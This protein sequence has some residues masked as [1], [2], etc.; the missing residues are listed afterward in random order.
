MA[1]A[2]DDADL[3]LFGLDRAAAEES[4]SLGKGYG[5]QPT[6]DVAALDETETAFFTLLTKLRTLL[7]ERMPRVAEDEKTYYRAMLYSVEQM[8]GSRNLK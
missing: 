2:P 6:I 3:E 4:A 1:Y 8:I 5:W 7:T